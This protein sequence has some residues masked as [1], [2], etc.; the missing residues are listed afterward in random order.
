[1][2][3]QLSLNSELQTLSA[4]LTQLDINF[5]S[6]KQLVQ[7]LQRNEKILQKK[8][9]DHDSDLSLLKQRLKVIEENSVLLQNPSNI[10]GPIQKEFENKLSRLEF[11]LKNAI[12]S[13]EKDV[14]LIKI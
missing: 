11:R 4:N 12:D 7:N 10:A 6:I 1:M 2:D 9:E 3:K 5:D 8:K 14:S 13:V